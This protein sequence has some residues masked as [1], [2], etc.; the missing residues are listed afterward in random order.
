M[1]T[2]IKICGK[3]CYCPL[4]AFQIFAIFFCA[5]AIFCGIFVLTFGLSVYQEQSDYALWEKSTCM[6]DMVIVTDY[7]IGHSVFW[8]VDYENTINERTEISVVEETILSDTN[9]DKVKNDVIQ[10]SLNTSH[11]CVFNR[12]T[13]HVRWQRIY[14]QEYETITMWTGIVMGICVILSILGCIGICVLQEE[15][16]DVDHHPPTNRMEMLKPGHPPERT[17]PEQSY[18]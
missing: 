17:H 15:Y 8:V 14:Y 13:L 7:Q 11:H 6:V 9:A 18:S 4:S 12:D 2:F 10:Y 1:N 3:K 16:E 5:S